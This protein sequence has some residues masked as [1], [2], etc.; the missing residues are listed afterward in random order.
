MDL[1]KMRNELNAQ[2]R[3][4]SFNTYDITVDELVRRSGDKEKLEVA[5][6]YQRE[7]RWDAERQSRLVESLFLGYSGSES[8]YWQP[9]LIPHLA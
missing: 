9:I 3:K 8:F 4:V 5:P 6:S 1:P 2:R 7:F